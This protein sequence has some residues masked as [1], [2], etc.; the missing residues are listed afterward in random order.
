MNTSCVLPFFCGPLA[1][2]S[3]NS[4]SSSNSDDVDSCSYMITSELTLM[5][6]TPCLR[7][8]TWAHTVSWRLPT[9][10]FSQLTC[11]NRLFCV[12]TPPIGGG[13]GTPPGSGGGGGT[14]PGPRGSGGGGGAREG[15]EPEV[16]PP[17]STRTSNSYSDGY[18]FYLF[19]LCRHH[20]LE[21]L[22]LQASLQD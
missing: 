3:S 18:S 8:P 11:F 12:A 2:C 9:L 16:N 7:F 6:P 14:P 22:L 10:S 21:A 17:I 4:M 19:V 15:E 5:Y 13:G 1:N 20:K